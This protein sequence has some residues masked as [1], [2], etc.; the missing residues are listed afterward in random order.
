M[1]ILPEGSSGNAVVP[2]EGTTEWVSEKWMISHKRLNTALLSHPLNREGLHSPNCWVWPDLMGH[3]GCAGENTHCSNPDF[4]CIPVPWPA[5]EPQSQLLSH[6]SEVSV[7]YSVATP[8][9]CQGSQETREDPLR[10]GMHR[11]GLCLECMECSVE[12]SSGILPTC[13]HDSQSLRNIQYWTRQQQ[14]HLQSTHPK[15]RPAIFVWLTVV[16][17]KDVFWRTKYIFPCMVWTGKV[18]WPTWLKNSCDISHQGPPV[19]SGKTVIRSPSQ[20]AHSIS[21]PF[22]PSLW[23]PGSH[24]RQIH[25]KTP[26]S[27]KEGNRSV[28]F[29]CS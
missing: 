1:W 9:V 15:P 4:P 14:L 16:H 29:K 25:I 26:Q 23:F 27:Y 11:R 21:S 18:A 28:C 2:G 10:P 13:I 22:P 12:L 8:A 19:V 5:M 24:R 6:K 3:P 7:S 20:A 17:G